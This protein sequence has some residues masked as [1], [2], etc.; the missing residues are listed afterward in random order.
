MN[1][2]IVAGAFSMLLVVSQNGVAENLDLEPC[3]NGSVSESG[4]FA[5]QT[6]EDLS[7]ESMFSSLDLEPC[8]NGAVSES[9]LFASQDE[10]DLYKEIAH[11]TGSISGHYE[12]LSNSTDP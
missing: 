8:I 6:E 12:L 1:K 4:L 2:L 11:N 10:E 3:I 7:K 9:G 5:L